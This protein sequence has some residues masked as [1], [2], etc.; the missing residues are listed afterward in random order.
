MPVLGHAFVGL[1]FGIST[2][3][4]LQGESSGDAT[5][6]LWVP[7]M[8][9]LAYLPDIVTQGAL[10]AGWDEGRLVGHSFI[11]ATIASALIGALLKRIVAISFARAFVCCLA[12]LVIHDILDLAQTTGRAPWW[13]LSDHAVNLGLGFLPTDLLGEGLLFGMLFLAILGLRYAVLPKPPLGHTPHGAWLGRTFFAAIILSA[14]LTHRSR[15]ER[16]LQLEAGR[17]LIEAGAYRAALDAL[18]GADRWPSTAKAGRID[19]LR[20]EAF[21]GIGDRRRAETHYLRAYTA[22]PT[23]FWTV[24]D[25]AFF[26]ASS[27]APGPERHRQAAPYVNRLR[28]EFS[29]HPAFSRILTRVERRLATSDASNAAAN[30]GG[31]E[32]RQ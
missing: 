15:D 8:V 4:P 2:R 17:A 1:A 25:L 12:S 5:A 21:A 13:P 31:L 7:A 30:M 10:L 28:T 6:T 11:F 29:G 19:H 9:T 23:Y 16:E 18:D 32:G 27:N 3:P 26:Y 24:A 22:D 20:A 14:M